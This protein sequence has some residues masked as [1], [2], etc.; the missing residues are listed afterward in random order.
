[1]SQ[2]LPKKIF[3]SVCSINHKVGFTRRYSFENRSK[4]SENLCI[5]LAGY[6]EFTWDIIFERINEFSDE[7]MDICV[8]SSGL[9]SEKLSRIAKKYGWSYLSTKRNC[10]TLIQNQAIKLFP[11][12]K[13]IYK[14]DED[15]FITKDFFKTLK[16]T[17]EYVQEKGNYNVGFVA[18]LINVN[19]YSHVILLEKLGLTDYY[20]EHFEKVKYAAGKDRMIENNP[21]VSKFMWGEGGIVPHID[22]LN[23]ILLESPFSYSASPITFSIGAIYFKRDIWE[24]MH[25]FLVLPY[26]SVGID[27]LQICAYCVLN[28]KAMIISENTCVGHLSFGSQNKPMEEYFKEHTECFEIKK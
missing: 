18:P 6:K 10:V 26:P 13:N 24:S 9:Y 25:Y 2:S 16:D 17:Y 12:A 4:N 5:I 11:N 1:M 22:D 23:N 14:L 27:E 21:D 19:G 28:S 7:D 15:I 8:L 3:N 20:N